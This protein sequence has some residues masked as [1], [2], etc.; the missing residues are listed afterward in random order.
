MSYC[1]IGT[2]LKAQISFP[3]IHKYH[4]CSLF[5]IKSVSSAWDI[6]AWWKKKDLILSIKFINRQHHHSVFQY[7]HIFY[8]W[9]LTNVCYNIRI[10]ILLIM[11]FCIYTNLNFI[12]TMINNHDTIYYNNHIFGFGLV[13]KTITV[14]VISNSLSLLQI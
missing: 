14:Y 8:K 1:Y 3:W 13:L 6:P 7:N 11:Y 10:I 12:C 9:S 2:L 5:F 4:D